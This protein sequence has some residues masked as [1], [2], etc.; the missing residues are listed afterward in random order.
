V[1]G[2]ILAVLPWTVAA[3]RSA[4]LQT[5]AVQLDTSYGCTVCHA[6]QRQGMVEGVHAQ[7]HVLCT[8]CHGGDA[9]ARSLPAAHRGN[10]TTGRDKV[11][12]IQ[13]CGS[14]HADP[15]KMRQ[16][17]LPTGQ[18]AEFRTSRHGQLLLV[19]HDPDAPACTNCHD[20][21]VIYPPDDA[22]S[23]VYPT[24]IPGTCA[25]CHADTRLMARYH[26]PTDQFEQFRSSAHGIALFQ[27][28]N[29]AAPTCVGCHGAHSA[30]PPS[31]TEIANVCGRCHGLV[32]QVFA[33]GPHGKA[34][35]AGRIPACLGCHSNHGTER[36]PAEQIAA[37]CQK[38]H[39]GDTQVLRLGQDIQQHVIRATNDLQSAQRAVAQLVLAGRRASDYRFRYQTALTY[40]L[41][42]AQVQHSLDLD[43]L[44][45]LSRRVHSISIELGGAAEALSE[46]RWE[47][48]L[49]LAPVWFLALSAVVL[50]WFTWRAL[51]EAD[52]GREP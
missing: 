14:C 19:Q 11:G 2:L 42:I 18:V 51:K 9:S 40:Y 5:P 27:H 37:V 17:G 4:A 46:Q 12:I 23:S 36:V 47:H 41:Q 13:M 6:E 15:N 50:A 1:W 26:I 48:K 22:R 21:H 43:R 44:E 3:A 7:F 35:A 49:I 8:A 52:E 16:Y 29:F 28:Q 34:A 38:C 45:E 10:F 24:N 20:A 31:V 33:A 39:A 30:L 32:A 25:R